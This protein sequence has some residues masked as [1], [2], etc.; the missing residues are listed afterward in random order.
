MGYQANLSAANLAHFRHS[1]S[2]KTIHAA[3]GW[4]NCW[5]TPSALRAFRQF[6]L[7]WTSAL[8]TAQAAG[9]RLEEFVVDAKTDVSRLQSIFQTRNIHGLLIPPQHRLGYW[10][11]LLDGKFD[12]SRFSAVRIGHSV[13]APLFS[14]VA[15]DQVGNAML[16]FQE[17]TNRGY[18]RIGYVALRDIKK[19]ARNWF[20]GG[21]YLAQIAQPAGQHVP[22]LY[23]NEDDTAHDAVRLK[24]WIVRHKPDAI[25]TEWGEVAP[26]LECLQIHVPQQLGLASLNTLDGGI[27]A[28][29]NQNPE[30]VGKASAEVLLALIN[31][32]KR[33]SSTDYQTTTIMGRWQDGLTLPDK[34]ARNANTSP[35]KKTVSS[36]RKSR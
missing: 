3:I 21:Y 4:I 13:P 20:L 10:P 25:L 22:V 16:A 6:D 27:E 12:W 1:N 9:Y 17:M 30:L 14:V 29:I 8:A 2:D 35:K 19:S 28:G 15:P 36:K 7:Y 34:T 24:N 23:L 5:Q 33:G 26:M 11:K 31:R 32:N 18:H